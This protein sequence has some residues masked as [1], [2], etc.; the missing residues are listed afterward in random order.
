M[1]SQKDKK[2]KEADIRSRREKR[3]RQF[4]IIIQKLNTLIEQ[5]K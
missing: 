2:T 5:F 1:S 4:R 3:E